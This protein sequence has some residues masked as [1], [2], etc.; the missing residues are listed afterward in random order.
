MG[1]RV[2]G[3]EGLSGWLRGLG[4]RGLWVE[5]GIPT[6]SGFGCSTNLDGSQHR[7]QQGYI[8]AP[9][10]SKTLAMTSR[11]AL[12]KHYEANR[13]NVGNSAVRTVALS[14]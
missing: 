11:K 14:S 8:V 4:S 2:Q 10:V 6:V 7:P 9:I 3:L 1:F 13:I 5:L 12:S